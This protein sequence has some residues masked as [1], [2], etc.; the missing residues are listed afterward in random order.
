MYCRR[1]NGHGL[2]DSMADE[3]LASCEEY[4]FCY[5]RNEVQH[6]RSRRMVLSAAN[7]GIGVV[8]WVE[9][10]FHQIPNQYTD[11]VEIGKD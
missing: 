7:L 4:Q 9:L 11:F 2:L 8:R 10:F 6:I 5:Q 3:C 1:R